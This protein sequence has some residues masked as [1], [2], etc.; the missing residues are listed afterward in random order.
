M[1]YELENVEKLAHL[2]FE[3]TEVAAIERKRVE[4]TRA[5]EAR[6]ARADRRT[7]A[8]EAQIA[9]LQR[10]HE[11]ELAKVETKL[12]REVGKL[13]T[14]TEKSVKETQARTQALHA[15][16]LE[17]E[18]ERLR[19][20]EETEAIK[21]QEEQLG[22]ELQEK[23]NA[24]DRKVEAALTQFEGEVTYMKADTEENVRQV[25]DNLQMESARVWGLEDVDRIMEE[26]AGAKTMPAHCPP[27]PER[28]A[29]GPHEAQWDGYG[30]YGVTT[31]QYPVEGFKAETA[32][33]LEIAAQHR[34][35]GMTEKIR[36]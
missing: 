28:L 11:E 16:R 33:R 35:L 12:N 13:R 19:L 8:A 34:R 26:T 25:I 22:L 18:A 20:M 14:Q 21:K 3:L 4:R 30:A 31:P 2:E 1:K 7:A 9:D 15:F 10:R 5:S 27:P 17:V 36:N 29:F 24:V 32:Q 6:I 23:I